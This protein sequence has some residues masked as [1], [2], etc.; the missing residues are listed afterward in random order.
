MYEAYA[1]PYALTHT[2]HF[3]CVHNESYIH[4]R[5]LDIFYYLCFKIVH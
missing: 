1:G 2:L 5:K 3:K 4:A